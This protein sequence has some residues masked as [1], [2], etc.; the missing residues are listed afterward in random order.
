MKELSEII[1]RIINEHRLLEG[2]LNDS[3]KIVLEYEKSIYETE[4]EQL[5][6]QLKSFLE[7]YTKLKKPHFTYEETSFFPRVSNK[8]SVVVNNL[9]NE[10]RS[11]EKLVEETMRLIGKRDL[12]LVLSNLRILY[13]EGVAHLRREDELINKIKNKYN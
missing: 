10:H 13:E 12:D 2:M 5:L 8:Y 4:K 7:N 9:I 3:I 11:M 1:K 6:K